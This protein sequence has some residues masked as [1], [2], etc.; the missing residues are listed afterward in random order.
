MSQ[1]RIGPSTRKVAEP[2]KTSFCRATTDS[3]TKTRNRWGKAFGLG[4]LNVRDYVAS[5]ASPAF[6][7][8]GIAK[9]VPPKDQLAEAYRLFA[10]RKEIEK[11][12]EKAIAELDDEEIG[13][14]DDLEDLV[15]DYLA[16]HPDKPWEDAV[17]HAADSAP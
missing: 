16:E 4:T 12:V 15:R 7:D 13:I 14:P 5:Y 6:E 3:S 2:A 10:R 9:V 8:A 11:A 17:R 1:K